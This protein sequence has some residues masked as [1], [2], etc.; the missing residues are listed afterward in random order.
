M[1]PI[2]VNLGCGAR[3]HPDWLNFDIHSTSPDVFPCNLLEG[4]P[5]P[6]ASCDAVY[7]AALLE[8][9][10]RQDAERFLRECHRILKP[11]GTLRIGVPDLE[12][13]ARI[14]LAKLE[15][16]VRGEPTAQPD[17]EWI[18]LELLDQ[19]TRTR[20]GGEML[21][22]IR[23]G[24]VNEQFVVERIGDEYRM[25]RASS[26]SGSNWR[27]RLRKMPVREIRHRVWRALAE[28]PNAVRRFIGSR[29]LSARDARALR[30][31]LFRV[32]GEA[33]QWMYDRYSLVG[34]LGRCGF[35]DA[36]VQSFS[37]SQIDADWSRFGL[38]A[39]EQGQPLKP[40]LI[41]V[42]CIK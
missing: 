32:S 11:G 5:L 31:G 10:P 39:N 4:V 17:Y 20:S 27:V 34:L 14:Y 28:A 36:T 12:R 25:L 30:V 22:A 13:I 15:A 40:D 19:L 42:E 35:R 6:D 18:L 23:N 37:L 2:L 33:H 8:H 21:D 9:L 38:D 3:H 7:N 1:K 41:F 26:S 24:T 29:I 16:G